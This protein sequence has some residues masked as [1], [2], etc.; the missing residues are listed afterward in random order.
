MIKWYNTF[1]ISIKS[2]ERFKCWQS[3]QITLLG[4]YLKEIIQN[5]IDLYTD[6]FI[7]NLLWWKIWMSFFITTSDGCECPEIR[8]SIK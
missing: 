2:M 5:V 7:T 4:I 6:F 3:H 1:R 8:K